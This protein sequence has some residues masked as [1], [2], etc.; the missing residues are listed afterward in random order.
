MTFP[1]KFTNQRIRSLLTALVALDGAEKIAQLGNGLNQVVRK[2][3]KLAAKTRM[4]IARNIANLAEA[5]SAFDKAHRGIIEEIAG[6][7]Q[8]NIDP[9][10]TDKMAELSKQFAELLETEVDLPTL[11][12]IK[13]SAL[14][15]EDNEIP[16]SVIADLM[17]LL[18]DDIPE[19]ASSA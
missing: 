10:D 15:V 11:A 19:E 3:Y 2:P 8:Q 17:P 13:A 5:R 1:M 18:D 9:A 14:N 4:A 7:G 12:K 16:Q 6:P